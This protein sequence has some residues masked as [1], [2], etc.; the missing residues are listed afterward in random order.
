MA[1]SERSWSDLSESAL[2]KKKIICKK[3]IL[4]FFTLFQSLGTL[5]VLNASEKFIGLYP[6]FIHN[7]I[8]DW[9]KIYFSSE[10]SGKKN[11]YIFK[12]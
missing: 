7:N 1:S 9:Y 11:E 3:K 12:A 6:V 10:E 8:W 5:K 2:F 4:L